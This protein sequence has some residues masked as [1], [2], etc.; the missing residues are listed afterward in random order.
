[1]LDKEFAPA[2]V[3]L[4]IIYMNIMSNYWKL[5]VSF[6][7][8]FIILNKKIKFYR[9]IRCFNM[10]IKSNPTYIRAYMCRAQTFRKIHNV[11]SFMCID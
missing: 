2:Y 5:V 9:A 1:L 11:N 7:I 8:V 4:G 10:A 3:N 6:M